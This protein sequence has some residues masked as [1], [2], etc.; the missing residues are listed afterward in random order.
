MPAPLLFAALA[1]GSR[2]NAFYLGTEE[3]GILIDV[4]VSARMLEARLE[5]LDLKLSAV[6]AIF[7]THEHHDHVAGLRVLARKHPVPVFASPGTLSRVGRWTGELGRPVRHGRHAQAAGLEAWAFRVPHDAREPLAFRFERAGS[8]VGFVTDMGHPA[9]ALIRAMEGVDLLYLE[10]NHDPELLHNGP[11]P[12]PL[13]KRIAG[14]RGHASNAQTAEFL[15]QLG[16]FPP[17]QVVLGHLSETNNSP[18]L[19]RA[20]AEGVL[21]SR[22]VRLSLV[23]PRRPQRFDVRAQ[24]LPAA[25]PLALEMNA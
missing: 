6:E 20:A 12:W 1:S 7:L 13:K 9:P 22:G 3:R 11:Y 19:A 4:G 21:G 10:A 15:A 23:G 16:L 5:A 24:R 14:N 18:Q 17:P 25:K 8:S 2:G